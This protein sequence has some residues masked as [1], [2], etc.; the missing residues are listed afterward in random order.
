MWGGAEAP[1]HDFCHL[2]SLGLTAKPVVI[3]GCGCI[4]KG[5]DQPFWSGT[6]FHLPEASSQIPTLAPLCPLGTTDMRS[7]AVVSET[8]EMNQKG[9]PIGAP[10][11]L[12]RLSIRLSISAQ[13]LIPGSCP[14]VGLCTERGACLRFSLSL[15]PFPLLTLSLSLK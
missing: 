4:P 5:C 13:V 11:W 9:T 12:S 14:A 6:S 2:N 8:S 1:L 3:W 15:C 10:G 7:S